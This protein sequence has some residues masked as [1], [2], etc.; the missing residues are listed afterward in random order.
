MAEHQN[1]D[2][3]CH[4]C[5]GNHIATDYK[6]S[7]I[8]KVRRRLIEQLRKHPEKLPPDFQLF[9]PSEYRNNKY[10]SR[11]MH[12]D[13]VCDQPNYY[14]QQVQSFSTS[15]QSTWPIRSNTTIFNTTD[16]S[17]LNE[18]TK[19]LSREMNEANERHEVEMRRIEKKYQSSMFNINTV[20]LIMQ[21]AQQT[22][23]TMILGMNTAVNQTMYGTCKKAS[24]QFQTMALKLK[25]QLNVNDFDDIISSLKLQIDYI[26]EMHSEFCKHLEDLHN[27][28]RLQG[29]ALNK[30]MDV[31][32][33]HI[34]E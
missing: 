24:E 8:D 17:N 4:H 20:C 19:N 3:K 5:E 13:E 26:D 16:N 21:Q 18:S 27:I 25:I 29:G 32:F 14:Y 2:I 1:C 28:S 10:D 9:I 30:A 34:H 11:I 23:Q 12:N 15:D 6:C 33:N 31:S 22:Q 7:L